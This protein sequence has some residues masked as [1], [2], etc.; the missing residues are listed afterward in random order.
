MHYYNIIEDVNCF[1][2]RV[3]PDLLPG[4]LALVE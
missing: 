4:V 2:Y 1:L 3:L